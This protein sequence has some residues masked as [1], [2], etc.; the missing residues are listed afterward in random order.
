MGL[1]RACRGVDQQLDLVALG[2]AAGQ[3]C[4]AGG[5]YGFDAGV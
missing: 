2:D 5:D 1:G 4:Y 3:H